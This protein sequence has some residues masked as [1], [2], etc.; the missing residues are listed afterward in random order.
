[1]GIKLRA[2]PTKPKKKQSVR[3]HVFLYGGMSLQNVLDGIPSTVNPK[4]VFFGT[5]R[6]YYDETEYEFEWEEEES[7][8]AFDKRVAAYNSRLKKWNQWYEENKEEVDKEIDRRAEAANIKKQQRISKEERD[9]R[10]A[11]SRLEKMK[12][13]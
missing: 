7:D 10:K 5:R 8:A 11:L 3:D 6:G 1:M 4:D 9:L 13:K 2:K 12:G